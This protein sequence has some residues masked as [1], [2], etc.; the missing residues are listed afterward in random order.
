MILNMKS[1][2]ENL[3]Q[4]K[5]YQHKTVLADLHLK[6]KEME[7]MLASKEDKI[8]ALTEENKYLKKKQFQCKQIKGG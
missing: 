4:K 7:I 5:E 2:H 8:S 1:I 6:F 3:Q